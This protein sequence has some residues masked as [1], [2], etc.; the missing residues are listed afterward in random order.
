MGSE[1]AAARAGDPSALGRVLQGCRAYLLTFANA[2]LNADLAAK[3]GASDLVQQSL[4]EAQQAFGRFGGTNEDELLR[5]LRRIVKNNLLDLAR[6]YRDTAARKIGQEMSLERDEAQQLTRRL[7]DGQRSPVEGLLALEKKIALESGLA[8]LP[9]EFRRVI[10]LRHSQ[11][12]TFAEIGTSLG[13]SAE[14]ARKLWFRALTK[15]RQELK[16][17][18]EFGSS[19]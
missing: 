15:L 4:L 11:G 3:E 19:C 5:W 9:E 13:K 14:A 6:R 8:C 12:R 17:H 16:R 18:E 7:A 10:E 2:E 1:L